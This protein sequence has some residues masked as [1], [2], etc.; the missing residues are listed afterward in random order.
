MHDVL[1]ELILEDLAVA[2]AL[3]GQDLGVVETGGNL[4]LLQD[5]HP[6]WMGHSLPDLVPELIGSEAALADILSG[7]L[8][9]LELDLV[10]RETSG[11]QILYLRMSILPHHEASGRITGLLYVIVD[12]TE[13]GALQQQLAQGR[14]QLWLLQDQ[15]E[16]QYIELAAANAELHRL[17]EIKSAFVSIAAHELRTPMASIQGYIE[18]LLD[19]E[20]GTFNEEQRQYL[21][22]VQ[23][24]AQRLMELS[25]TLLDMARI[26]AGQ[27]DLVLQPTNIA[28]LLS[29]VTTEL[30][31]LLV[32]NAQVLSLEISPDL[33]AILCDRRRAAQI[34]GN[35]LSNAS[36]YTPEGG[37]I[38]VMATP[39]EEVGFVQ[40][41]ISDTGVGIPAADKPKLFRRFFRTED[42]KRANASGA[43]LGLSISQSLVELHGGRIWFDSEPRQGSRFYVTFPAAEE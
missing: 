11:G 32:A 14:N 28:D 26:E 9:R 21:E 38:G 34:I 24:S 22:V 2:Y 4:Q 12:T 10:N 25:N 13:A 30:G 41:S 29:Q 27:I 36:K 40:I 23:N 19:E 33:P 37:R 1:A 6:D 42:A 43:G 39:A 15:L 17:S 35:L 7:K 3:T 5:G 20:L 18:V 16:Y 8:R 31:S